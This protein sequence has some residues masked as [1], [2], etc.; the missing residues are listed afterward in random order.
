ML[1]QVVGTLKCNRTLCVE[2]IENQQNKTMKSTRYFARKEC[3]K[4]LANGSVDERCGA[5]LSSLSLCG[6]T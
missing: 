1:P 2:K 4:I 5:N 6:I 3:G